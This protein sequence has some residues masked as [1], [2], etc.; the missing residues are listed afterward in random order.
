[1]FTM[2]WRH[3]E[4][5]SNKCDTRS[6]LTFIKADHTEAHSR[7]I[8]R[9]TGERRQDVSMDILRRPTL[10]HPASHVVV[11]AVLGGRRP[12]VDHLVE[13]ELTTIDGRCLWF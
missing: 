12:Q 8:S 6:L 5:D 9:R 11:E 1:M 7:N 4:G 10:S 2:T 3:W 13:A